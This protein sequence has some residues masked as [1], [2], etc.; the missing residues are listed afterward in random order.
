MLHTQATAVPRPKSR[1]ARGELLGASAVADRLGRSPRTIQRWWDDGTLPCAVICG[2]RVM[3][4]AMLDRWL[5]A[6]DAS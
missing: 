6:L 5:A 3:T 1:P 4:R 2:R